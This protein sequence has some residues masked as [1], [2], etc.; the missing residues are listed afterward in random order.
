MEEAQ[1][2]ERRGKSVGGDLLKAEE[3]GLEEEEE[4]R[5]VRG[6]IRRRGERQGGA[7]EI[8]GEGEDIEKVQ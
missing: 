7:G 8:R 2:M 4:D 1:E 3:E 6:R 5:T